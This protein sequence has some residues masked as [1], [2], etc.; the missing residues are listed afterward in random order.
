ML[1]INITKI[2]VKSNLINYYILYAL[3]CKLF[4]II[5][6]VFKHASKIRSRWV[7]NGNIK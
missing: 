5:T 1:F 7:S 6:Y 4:Y 2:L 3:F